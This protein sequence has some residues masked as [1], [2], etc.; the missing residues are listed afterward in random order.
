MFLNGNSLFETKLTEKDG[1]PVA[2]ERVT[3]FGRGRG[4]RAV[5]IVAWVEGN[6]GEVF[7]DLYINEVTLVRAGQ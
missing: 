7:K 3:I 2:E 1:T 6:D 5:S 4:N